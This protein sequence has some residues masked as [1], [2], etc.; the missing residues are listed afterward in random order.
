MPCFWSQRVPC[1]AQDVKHRD[2]LRT[3][4]LVLS[5]GILGFYFGGCIRPIGGLQNLPLK[6][7]GV[8]SGSYLS[9]LLIILL[10]ILFIL[11][12]GR[13]FC[14]SVC[15]MGAFQELLFK[16]GTRLRL[17]RGRPG[18]EKIKWIRFIKYLFWPG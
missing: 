4:M 12:A 5:L 2:A 18:L 16:L 13:I 10:P 9:W 7:A 8:I 3:G 6:I 15:P 1:K 17:N 11:I 14:S